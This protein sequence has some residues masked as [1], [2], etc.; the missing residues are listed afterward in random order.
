M[1]DL[2]TVSLFHNTKDNLS[3]HT[4]ARLSKCHSSN[5]IMGLMTIL[6]SVNHICDLSYHTFNFRV[7]IFETCQYLNYINCKYIFVLKETSIGKPNNIQ[8]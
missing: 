8:V 7:A 3:N 4:F 1:A 6:P 5:L 2:S